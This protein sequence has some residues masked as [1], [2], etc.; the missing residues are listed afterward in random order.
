MVQLMVNGLYFEAKTYF[1]IYC[2]ANDH[3]GQGIKWDPPRRFFECGKLTPFNP[4]E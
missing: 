3:T 2:C 1:R 4:Y